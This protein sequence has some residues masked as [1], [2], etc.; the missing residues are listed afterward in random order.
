MPQARRV[1]TSFGEVMTTDLECA[2]GD[3]IA[4]V[5]IDVPAGTICYICGQDI[6]DEPATTAGDDA[7]DGKS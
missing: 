1:F 3:E 5:D 2:C 6:L 7:I 4:A